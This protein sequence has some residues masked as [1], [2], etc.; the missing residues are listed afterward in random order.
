LIDQRLR[1]RAGTAGCGGAALARRVP[2]PLQ[3]NERLN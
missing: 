3:N 2:Y 1:A